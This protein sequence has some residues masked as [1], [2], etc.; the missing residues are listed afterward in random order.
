[1]ADFNGDGENQNLQRLNRMEDVIQSMITLV[2]AQMEV[3]AAQHTATMT[4]I[5][6]LRG[7]IQELLALQR[8]HRIDIMALFQASKDTKQRLDDELKNKPPA[9]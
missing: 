3:T 4:E 2:H 8:E 9:Q 6:E 5:R 1:M 7:S